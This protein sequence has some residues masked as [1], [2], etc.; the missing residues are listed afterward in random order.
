MNCAS[1]LELWHTR[2]R[3]VS[4][5][6]EPSYDDESMVALMGILQLE[7]SGL[8]AARVILPSILHL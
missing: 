4:T 6:N 2:P 5:D 7:S 1:R 3:H 8:I